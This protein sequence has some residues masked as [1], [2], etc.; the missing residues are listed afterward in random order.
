MKERMEAKSTL[1]QWLALGAVA[2]AIAVLACGCSGS[3]GGSNTSA[4]SDSAGQAS[5]ESSSSSSAAVT[6]DYSNMA[7]GDSITLDNGL[8]VS[9]DSVKS[10]LQ[11]YDGSDVTAVTVTYTNNGSSNASFNSYDWKAEDANGAQRDTTYYSDASDELNYGD[12]SSGGTV[13]GTVYFD[14]PIV[15]VHYYSSMLSNSSTAAWAVS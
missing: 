11:N 8:V 2:L 13:T 5:T 7:V 14:S 10:G 15:K 6:A 12:L 1:R 4:G 9:V 3:G